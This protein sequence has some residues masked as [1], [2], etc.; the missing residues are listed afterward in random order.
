MTTQLNLSIYKNMTYQR[1]L[2]VLPIYIHTRP[3]KAYGFLYN[4][5]IPCEKN[6]LPVD[7][8]GHI[9]NPSAY[10]LSLID[11]SHACIFPIIMLLA[12]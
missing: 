4:K 3:I 12:C 10:K 5:N 9:Q 6:C 11:Q 8:F 2:Y 1:I 7:R